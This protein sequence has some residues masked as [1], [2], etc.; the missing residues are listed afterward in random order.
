MLPAPDLAYLK[1]RWPGHTLAQH[2]T[3]VAVVLPEF[4]LPEGF[5]PQTVDMLLQLPFGF[6]ETAPDMF[7]VDPG[8]TLNG[9]VP[10]ATEVRETVI[11]RSWQRFSRHLPPGAWKPGVDNLQSWVSLIQTMLSREACTGRAAA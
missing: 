2:G 4:V 6:P 1:E 11:G 9:H 7:W 5:A 8:V 10:P 3:S